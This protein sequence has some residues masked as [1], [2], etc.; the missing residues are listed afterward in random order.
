MGNQTVL[1]DE[2]TRIKTQDVVVPVNLY[3]DSSEMVSDE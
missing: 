2:H 3:L 1:S